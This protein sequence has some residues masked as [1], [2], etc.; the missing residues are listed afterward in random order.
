MAERRMFHSSVVESDAFLDLPAGAQALYFHMGMHADDDGFVNCPKQILRKLRRPQK[1]LQILID[2][3]FLL[4]FDGIVVLRHWRLANSLKNDRYKALQYPQLAQMLYILPNRIYTLNPEEKAESLLLKRQE[5]LDSKWN[6]KGKE[7]KRTEKKRTEKKGKE[8]ELNVTEVCVT[9]AGDAPLGTHEPDTEFITMHG[10]LGKGVVLL[11][12]QQQEDLL[13]KL[14]LDGFDHYV[15]KLANFILD[16][17]ANI[18][19]HYA[20]ILK[21]W[22]EDR[23]V[24]S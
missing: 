5:S 1:D 24:K 19:N 12:N 2:E 14:G 23:S 10:K 13:D 20:T 4:D 3:Q 7:K 15:E 6:P 21:W 17:Q 22:N 16:N 9:E 18:R 11:T 8:N